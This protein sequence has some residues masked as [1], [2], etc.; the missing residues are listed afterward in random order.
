MRW[1]SPLCPLEGDR[2]WPFSPMCA[3]VTIFYQAFLPSH[4]CIIQRWTQITQWSDLK[5]NQ[6]LQLLKNS[7]RWYDWYNY[8][9][10]YCSERVSVEVLIYCYHWLFS[11]L[12]TPP[13]KMAS[14]C[15][16]PLKHPGAWM[17]TSCTSGEK[18]TNDAHNTSWLNIRLKKILMFYFHK[19]SL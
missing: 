11:D 4:D 10:M 5:S 16:S 9:K 7:W 15:P 17:P 6:Q 3:S 13:R 14:L 1:C 18:N 12:S 8:Y 19:N 2:S